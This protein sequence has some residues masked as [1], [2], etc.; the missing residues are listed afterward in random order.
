METH[1]PSNIVDRSAVEEVRR[2]I[3]IFVVHREELNGQIMEESELVDIDGD[4]GEVN[5]MTSF[6]GRSCG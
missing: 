2:T 1:V 4:E 6:V 5:V 3:S